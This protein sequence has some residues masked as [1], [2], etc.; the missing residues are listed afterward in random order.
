MQ[1]NASQIRQVLMNLC[2]NA[3]DA[4]GDRSGGAIEVGLDAVDLQIPVE[5][6][7]G[8]IAPGA[9]HRLRVADNGTG[10]DEATIARIFEPFY[11]TKEPGKGTG[12]GLAMVHTIVHSHAG[13]LRV[14][15]RPGAGTEFEV[16]LPESSKGVSKR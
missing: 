10:M 11:T 2:V 8:R 14:T 5:A 6:V 1:G 12:L 16:Y 15:S 7:G 9:Y 13:H 4:I 3:G